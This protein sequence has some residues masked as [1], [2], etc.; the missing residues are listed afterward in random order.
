MCAGVS[1]IAQAVLFGLQDLL[2]DA[3]RSEM[4]E[5]YLKVLV[6]GDL[7]CKEGPRAVLRT[8]ELGLGAVQR[9]YPGT[10]E[11]GEDFESHS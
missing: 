4:C 10:M 6:N 2:G 8:L 1:A 3:V 7:A 11:I 5:G 9:S